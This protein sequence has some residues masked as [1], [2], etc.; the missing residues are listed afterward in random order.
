MMCHQFSVELGDGVRGSEFRIVGGFGPDID[1][2][3]MWIIPQRMSM[4]RVKR[5]VDPNA[6]SDLRV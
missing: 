5:A 6:C 1:L 4:W 3:N 2:V